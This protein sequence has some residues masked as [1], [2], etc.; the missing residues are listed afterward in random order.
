MVSNR[1][2]PDLIGDSSGRRVVDC[3]IEIKLVLAT[4]I[5][6]SRDEDG[7]I[8]PR[9]RACLI[10]DRD[11]NA[12]SLH[13]S[14]GEC[15]AI[16]AVASM[17]RRVGGIDE[18]ALISADLRVAGLESHR[19]ILEVLGTCINKWEQDCCCFAIF[20]QDFHTRLLSLFHAVP[21]AVRLVL[22][23]SQRESTRHQQT[24]SS[25]TPMPRRWRGRCRSHSDAGLRR[26]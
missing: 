9:L 20:S 25:T 8:L 1:L 2:V 14:G 4:G 24:E 16:D 18:G 3:S 13:L 23:P 22:P 5:A 19:R 26:R 17:C 7:L 15:Q 6:I 21:H 10:N 11:H 12:S